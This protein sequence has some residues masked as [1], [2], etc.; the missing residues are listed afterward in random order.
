LR[1]LSCANAQAEPLPPS[2]RLRRGE[3]TGKNFPPQTPPIFA[4]LLGLRPD[5]FRRKITKGWWVDLG[6]LIIEY[7]EIL[8]FSSFKN[9]NSQPNGWEFL[10][11]QN[12]Y[13]DRTLSSWR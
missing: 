1:I 11:I 3:Q 5:F 6:F 8:I 7:Q 4:R 12:F 10:Y 13:S 9:K 2:P